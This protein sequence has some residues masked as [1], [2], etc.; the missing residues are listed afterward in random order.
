VN[1][2]PE[3]SMYAPV[4]EITVEYE[5]RGQ[6]A[7]RHLGWCLGH[8]GAW[9]YERRPSAREDD[10]IAIHRFDLDTA[11]RLAKQQ[12]PLVTVNGA[13]AVDVLAQLG[14]APTSCNH[15]PAHCWGCPGGCTSCRCHTD[16]EQP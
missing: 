10:W 12:A 11:L 14:E 9:D 16:Q 4:F 2:L 5:G 7:I 15:R 1:L 6:W 8:E 13:T 3:T